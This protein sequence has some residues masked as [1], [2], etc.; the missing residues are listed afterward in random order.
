MTSH[1]SL[2]CLLPQPVRC[3]ASITMPSLD[4]GSYSG[5]D[6][7][8]TVAGWG[9]TSENGWT[10]SVLRS[11]NL[12]LLD[13]AQCITYSIIL[14]DSMICAIGDPK[15][16][17][18]ACSGDSGGPLFVQQARA[19]TAPPPRPPSTREGLR[20]YL[21]PLPHAPLT[22]TPDPLLGWAGRG[23]HHR[24]RCLARLRLRAEGTRRRLHA[25]L[26][27]PI[28]D[29]GDARCGC[30]DIP[31]NALVPALDAPAIAVAASTIDRNLGQWQQLPDGLLKAH[32]VRGMSRRDGDVGT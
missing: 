18:D 29:R 9:K 17:E 7:T 28:L 26:L 16:G 19:Y 31:A 15:G 1:I 13:N 12:T 25:R 32:H 22:P 24:R 11:V 27:L 10:S 21:P 2:A 6:T 23:G 3:A 8:A 30:G 4:D 20:S 5:A 14:A